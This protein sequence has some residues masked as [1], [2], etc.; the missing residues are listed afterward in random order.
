MHTQRKELQTGINI[1]GTQCILLGCNAFTDACEV[2][3]YSNR[4]IIH[5][6][7][8]TDCSIIFVVKIFFHFIYINQTKHYGY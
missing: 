1:R 5:S 3:K 7:I 8:L 2:K 4:L 6:N